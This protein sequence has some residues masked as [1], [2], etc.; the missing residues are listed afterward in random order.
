MVL[1]KRIQNMEEEVTLLKAEIQATLVDIREGL[2]NTDINA[3]LSPT[4]FPAVVH[5]IF[6]GGNGRDQGMEGMDS[7]RS[8]A[9]GP[10]PTEKG[11]VKVNGNDGCFMGEASTQ[12]RGNEERRQDDTPN[13]VDPNLMASLLRWVVL[14]RNHIGHEE[15]D[16]FMEICS[17]SGGLP[18]GVRHLVCRIAET[19]RDDASMDEHFYSKW[20]DLMLQLHGIINPARFCSKSGRN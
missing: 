18:E 15:L 13:T 9:L 8:A 11:G 3:V 10:S 4:K 12:L 19:V 17:L 20:S 14:T 16:A 1:E 6:N 5:S 7:G 2:L